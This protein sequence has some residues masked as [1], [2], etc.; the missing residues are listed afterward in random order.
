MK[1]K[2][3]YHKMT[4]GSIPTKVDDDVNEFMGGRKVV[5]VKRNV[6]VVPEERSTSPKTY[7]VTTVLYEE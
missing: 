6:Q 1:I 5:D 7:I 3:F 4:M 2:T